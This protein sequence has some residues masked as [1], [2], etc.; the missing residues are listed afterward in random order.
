M[1]LCKGITVPIPPSKH[2]N[3]RKHKNEGF[4]VRKLLSLQQVEA[5]NAI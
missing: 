2:K 1:L 5:L 3:G 4:L